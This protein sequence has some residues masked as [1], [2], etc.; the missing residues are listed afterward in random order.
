[1]V[2]LCSVESCV[3]CRDGIEGPVIH[4]PCGDK[5]DVG[6]LLDL[7]R[8][9]MV[10]E[11]LFPPACC[12]KPFNFDDI[13]IYLDGNLTKLVERKTIEFGTEDRVYCHQPTCSAFLGA[14]TASAANLLC[15]ACWKYTCAHCKKAAHALSIR[16]ATTE[17][18][19]V[20]ALA[21]K[22][23]WKRCPGCGHLVELS[24]GC[25]HMTCRCRHQ[26]CYLCTAR[27]K[28]CRCTQWDED[29]LLVAAQDRVRRQGV[30]APARGGLGAA[31]EFRQRVAREAERMRV[32]HNCTHR[33]RYVVTAGNCEG[34]GHYLPQ[35]L[36]K[37]RDCQM[38]VCAR[39]RRNRWV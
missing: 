39:C 34:C 2:S 38:W 35:F 12:R 17:D 4:A 28:T 31:A 20:V 26:F 15:M 27:W 16:C 29:R 9:A 19:A 11:S 14:A 7:Y 10:D 36:F 21:E 24:I 18:A 37:C 8:A 22:E 5:Y 1:M 32:D 13:R 33:W 30:Q 3:I 23:G 6:C 25:Y